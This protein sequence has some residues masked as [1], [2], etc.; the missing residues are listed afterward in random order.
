[1]G[2]YAVL[3][4]T[5]DRASAGDYDSWELLGN[6]G[7]GWDGL[8]PYFQKSAE[9]I[10]PPEEIV[11]KY[12]YTYDESAYSDDGYLKGTLPHWQV[13]D[14]YTMFDGFTEL[15][16]PFIEEHAAGTAIGQF[17][18]PASIDAKT[19]TR[20]SS[21]TSYY[22]SVSESHR[23]LEMLN[24][25][26]V[27]E[28]TFEEDGNVVSG[29]KALNRQTNE[30]VT[31]K[32][33]RE[34]I[35]AAG[36]I[37]TPQILQLSGIGPKDVVEA[38]GIE[39]RIDL[40]AVGSNFQDHPVAYLNWTVTNTYPQPDIMTT[41]ATFAAEALKEYQ[42]HL[43]GPYTKAQSN[44]VAFLSFPM[45]TDDVE[46]ILSSLAEQES[47]LHLPETYTSNKD[48]I[49]GYEAQR[50]IIAQQLEE[51][52]VAALEFPFG[53]TGFVPNAVEKPL[54]RG[55]V[56]LNASDPHGEPIVT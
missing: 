36:A 15:G 22:D 38:A 5:L 35:L 2:T 34:V 7:W 43:T 33:K 31:F 18:V 8:E 12:N 11:E 9:F 3:G 39:S 6:P 47:G 14:T 49:A 52:T 1:M 46:S 16:V 51:G 17:W 40:P 20:S 55:T 32:A 29:V 4:M 56:H 45:V 54:S 26:Q 21:L 42:E 44:S 37:H 50:D 48:L 10:A 30:E 27:T 53:G 24:E 23:N 19:Q 13:P 28:L 41:N 25:Y